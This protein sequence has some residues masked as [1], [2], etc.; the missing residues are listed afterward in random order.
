MELNCARLRLVGAL[1]APIFI[2]SC[3]S[4]PVPEDRSELVALGEA[5][6]FTETFEGNGRTCGTCH[7]REDNFG[8]SPAF[9]AKLVRNDPLFVAERRRALS[10]NFEKPAQMRER[11]L[12]LEN[13]DGFDDLANNFNLRG[14]P[15]VLSLATSVASRDGPRTGWSGDG[16]PGDGSLRAFAVGAVIQHLPR[17]LDRTVGSDFRLP[18]DAELDAIEAFML[19]LGRQRDLR[20]PL[21]L[22]DPQASLGHC[23]L[24]PA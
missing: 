6:F 23:R 14:V 24:V 5:L 2:A 11:G 9:I 4:T 15:H 21:A 18:T 10:K 13:Q 20:L 1:V 3:Q 7:R 12:I 17:T 8:L 19:S 16:A 22:Q